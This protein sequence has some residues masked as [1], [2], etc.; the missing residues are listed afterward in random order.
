MLSDTELKEPEIKTSCFLPSAVRTPGAYSTASR[1]FRD[2][3][4]REYFTAGFTG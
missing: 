3:V 1:R 2:D 4:E